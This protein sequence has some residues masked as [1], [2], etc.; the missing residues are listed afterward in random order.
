[1]ILS[2]VDQVRDALDIVQIIGEVVPL[3]KQSGRFLGLCPFHQE[4]TPSFTVSQDKQLFHC[5]GCKAGGNIFHFVQ[6]YYHWDF[7]QA[8]EE[9]ARKAGVDIQNRG[10]DRERDEM[11]LV[12][13]AS[14][15]FFEEALRGSGGE[16][17]RDYLKRRHIPEELWK[18]F[19]L[20][21][22]PGK[23][24]ALSD[25]LERGGFSRD[26]AA[27]LGLLGRSKSGQWMDRYR[28]RLIFPLMDERGRVR[29]FGARSLG[30]EMPKYINSPASP[31]FDKKQSLYGIQIATSTGALSKADFAI[32]VEGYL[33]V[34]ALHEFGLKQSLGTMGTALS[35]EQ[36]RVI[37]RWTNRVV[38]LFDADEAGL[39]ATEKSLGLF[40]VEG[41][42]AKIAFT[43]GSKDP[44]AFL[45][46]Q[47][48]SL[49]ER[50]DRLRSIFKE[51]KPALDYLIEKRV[52]A[53]TD[54]IRRAKKVRSLVSL[55]NKMPDPVERGVLKSELA[56]RFE[57]PIGL[58]DEASTASEA[59]TVPAFKA[60]Q[61]PSGAAPTGLKSSSQIA[62]EIL[63]FLVL[64]GKAQHF[65]LSDLIPYFSFSSHEP[66]DKWGKLL[67]DLIR[68]GYD[69]PTIAGLSWLENLAGQE[70]LDLQDQEEIQ[71]T[72]REWIFEST[73]DGSNEIAGQTEI[74]P[75]AIQGQWRVL[76]RKLKK[77]Y[78]ERES[79]R[80][81]EALKA[82][83]KAKDK[84]RSKEV[85]RE[86][87]ALVDLI[88][89]NS[90]EN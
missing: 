48:L 57:L 67:G 39:A 5:F 70:V 8:L 15:K 38:S 32:L 31:V 36:L 28:S 68:N 44:D 69:T 80:L 37:K 75:Q 17:A 4:K 19:R 66:M 27:R 6:K 49:K 74:E 89:E 61:R 76:E 21:A 64:F 26:T 43:P 90:L 18:D 77:A 47:S 40:M 10:V 33:D 7:P 86:K 41:I 79:R 25:F 71:T 24:A 82:A 85:L 60:P 52:L 84:S 87:Q 11:F 78:F 53:E 23:P 55:L 56:R 72:V 50:K 88:R 83:E 45:H 30:N 81:N 63:K 3:K 62:R 54:S 46:D 16:E 51:A 13:E 29:G 35:S 20:G 9:L 58:M 65:S 2:V 12:L 14:A 22:H 1:M 59:P 42:E 73:A 34:I